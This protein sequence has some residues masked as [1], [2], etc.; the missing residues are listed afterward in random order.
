MITP[1]VHLETPTNSGLIN[2]NEPQDLHIILVY[3]SDTSYTPFDTLILL[4]ESILD[5]N[6]Y[7]SIERSNEQASSIQTRSRLQMKIF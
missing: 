6:N 2:D 4:N 3:S 7:G 1:Y 5:N